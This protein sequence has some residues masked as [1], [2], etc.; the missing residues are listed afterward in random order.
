MD[1]FSKQT[2]TSGKLKNSHMRLQSET[3]PILYLEEENM[4]L[5]VTFLK[6]YVSYYR[7]RIELEVRGLVLLSVFH[8]PNLLG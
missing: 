4:T 6:F 7:I 2:K 8:P 5:T 3:E 1:I